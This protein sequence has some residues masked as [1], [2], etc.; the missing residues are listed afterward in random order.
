MA[1]VREADLAAAEDTAAGAAD[2]AEEA[3]QAHGNPIR[4]NSDCHAAENCSSEPAQLQALVQAFHA[5]A[6]GQALFQ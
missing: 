6:G 5:Y 1:A 3:H 4:N 2:L